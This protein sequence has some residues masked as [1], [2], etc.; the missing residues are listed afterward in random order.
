[1]KYVINIL[2]GIIIL[3]LI[4]IIF[5]K[6]KVIY[7]KENDII[8]LREQ[9]NRNI[10]AKDSVVA[11]M[12][13]LIEAYNKELFIQEKETTKIIKSY[14]NRLKDLSNVTIVTDDSITKYISNRI[15]DRQSAEGVLHSD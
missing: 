7:V 8:M 15:R 6:N 11:D 5:Q 13:K 3:A 4:Y 2:M 1:M 12:A 10:I 14:E 9:Y